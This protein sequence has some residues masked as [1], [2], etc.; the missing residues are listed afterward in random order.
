MRQKS[1]FHSYTKSFFGKQWV[2]KLNNEG[3]YV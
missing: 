1:A 2:V 3:T